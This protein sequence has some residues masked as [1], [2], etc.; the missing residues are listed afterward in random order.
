M[1]GARGGGRKVANY[2]SLVRE[3]LS[4]ERESLITAVQ[5]QGV[6]MMCVQAKI[7]GRREASPESRL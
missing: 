5:E 6:H 3:E 1:R 7:E 2:K 4:R